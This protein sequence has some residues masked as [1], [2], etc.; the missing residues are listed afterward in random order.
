MALSPGLERPTRL[1]PRCQ[2]WPRQVFASSVALHVLGFAL[3][4]W[5]THGRFRTVISASGEQVTRAY[6]LH[7]LVLTRPPT[8]SEPRPEPLPERRPPSP[9]EPVAA[10]TA[11]VTFP[12]SIN[13]VDS[14]SR[15]VPRRSAVQTQE[16]APGETLGI[17][18][19][20]PTPHS[21]SAGRVGVAG[22]L[23][24]R[25]PMSGGQPAGRGFERV[26]ELVGVAGSACPELRPPAVWNKRHFAVAVTFVVDTSGAVDPATLRVIESP[27]RPQTEHRF[28]SRIYVV[29][30]TVRT[31]PGDIDPAAYDSVVTAEVASHVAGLA[32]RPALRKGRAIRSTVL[33][34]CQTS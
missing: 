20:I 26:A 21:D 14:A 27:A 25:V 10:V 29:G 16:L 3:A 7:Y 4:G 23:G 2:P 15:S 22:L 6:A 19:I 33:V 30:A 28:H 9:P 1:L 32:F 34:S 17:G 13:V 11:S 12:V 31:D 18:Q 5:V 24:L 8:R